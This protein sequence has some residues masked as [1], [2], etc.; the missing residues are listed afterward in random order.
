MKK[1]PYCAE[2]IQDEAIKCRYCNES[3]IQ[4]QGNDSVQAEQKQSIEKKANVPQQIIAASLVAL[5]ILGLV[6]LYVDYNEKD[7][8]GSAGSSRTSSSDA[9]DVVKRN[10]NLD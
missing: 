1:C 4:E 8:P 10:W 6:F 5:V 2:V 9:L 3:L 7:G